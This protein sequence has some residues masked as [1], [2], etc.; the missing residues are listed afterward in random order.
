MKNFAEIN[1]AS[2]GAK[3]KINFFEK[4]WEHSR[5]LRRVG[6]VLVMCLITITQAWAVNS[7]FTNGET[8]FFYSEGTGSAWRDDACVKAEFSNNGSSSTLV[9][10]AWLCDATDNA[11]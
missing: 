1:C 7:T 3:K 2:T 5:T 8:I 4:L 10:S 11:N 9:T 6:L